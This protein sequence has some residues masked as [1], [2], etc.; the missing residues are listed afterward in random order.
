MSVRPESPS[1][2]ET[3]P[4]RY[5]GLDRRLIAYGLDILLLY[6]AILISQS[7]VFA[8]T[9]GY[10]IRL[11]Q[12]GP[13]L[14]AWVLLTVSLPTW[15]Y[16]ALQERSP[17][18]ATPGKRWLGIAVRDTGDGT[19]GTGR[20]LMRTAIKLL[21]WEL[22]HLTI[23]LPIPLWWDPTPG[24]RFGLVVV[25]ALLGLYMLTMIFSPRKQGPHDFVARTVVVDLRGTE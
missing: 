13:R 8:A 18:G 16:F 11:L 1:L 14:E 22:T 23:M 17:R 6:G 15:L 20:A 7:L 9:R 5:A 24:F 25:Y 19:V 4:T 21:P 12:T 3:A 2:V 10:L